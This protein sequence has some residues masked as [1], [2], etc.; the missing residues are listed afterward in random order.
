MVAPICVSAPDSLSFVLLSS[1]RFAGY[2][3]ANHRAQAIVA[4]T[5]PVKISQN[6]SNRGLLNPSRES[7]RRGNR[8][9]KAEHAATVVNDDGNITMVLW[10]PYRQG[11]PRSRQRSFVR[12]NYISEIRRSHGQV[13]GQHL[14]EETL[15]QLH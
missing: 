14:S 12:R 8:T 1:Q 5:A 3:S 2:G 4:F 9:G 6:G 11:H 10:R 13:T 7:I 15:S